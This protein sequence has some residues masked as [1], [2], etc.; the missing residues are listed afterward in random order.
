MHFSGHGSR[1]GEIVLSTSDRGDQFVSTA[2]LAAL[3]R[4]TVK[5]DTR[6]V[7]LNACYSAIQAHAISQ[8]I[9]YVIGMRAPMDDEAAA[10]FAAA[11]Y[12]ALAFRRTVAEAFDQAKVAIDCGLPD[13]SVPE[14]IIRPGA[15]PHAAAL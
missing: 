11:F 13:H 14:L 3:F 9:D 10:V 4:R 1:S 15:G 7:V 12:S 2:A 6:M 5:D 8:H